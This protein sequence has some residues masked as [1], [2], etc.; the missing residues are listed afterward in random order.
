MFDVFNGAKNLFC[1]KTFYILCKDKGLKAGFLKWDCDNLNSKTKICWTMHI[2][3]YGWPHKNIS[4][5]MD[6]ISGT[7]P[8][9]RTSI[10]YVLQKIEGILW[11]VRIQGKL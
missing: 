4:M 10:Y 7:N 3:V 9:S 1:M 6:S 5:G 11:C 8:I 2:L